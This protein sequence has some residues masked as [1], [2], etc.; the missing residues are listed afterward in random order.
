MPKKVLIVGAG[1]AGVEAA[2]KLN[3]RA[4]KDDLEITLVDKNPYHTLLT[5]I[6]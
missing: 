4:K 3:K 2:L 5:E 1:Y 6:H